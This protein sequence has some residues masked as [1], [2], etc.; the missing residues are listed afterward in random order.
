MKETIRRRVIDPGTRD[1]WISVSYM[2]LACVML[3][4]HVWVT[5]HFATPENGALALRFPWVILAGAGFF[6]GR[7]W[8]DKTFWILAALLLLKMLRV[9]VP[10]PEKLSDT[11]TVY[12]LCLYAFGICYAAGRVLDP[13][14]RKRFVSLFCG[15]WT[16]A[17]AALA[18]AGLYA[19]WNNA[20]IPNLGNKPIFVEKSRLWMVYHPVEGGGLASVTVA[21]AMIGIHLSRRRAVKALYGAAAA[22]IFLAGVF[23]NSRTS[24]ILSAFA[25]SA[26]VCLAAYEWRN[27]GKESRRQKALRIAGACLLF[28]VLSLALIVLQTKIM[29]L[30]NAVRSRG[31]AWVPSALA[32]DAAAAAPRLKTREFVLDKGM[33]GFLTDRV[34][35]WAKALEAM[36]DKPSLF[37][38]GQSVYRFMEPLR[39][40]G[41]ASKY[42][43]H[44]TFMQTLW[45][46]GIPGL[47][48]FAGF[49]GIFAVNA[50]RLAADRGAPRWMRLLPL[51]AVLCWMADFVDCTGYCN[52]GKPAMTVLYFF[53]GLTIAAALERRKK[54]RMKD[55]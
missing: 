12:E 29:P 24:D 16:A 49:F 5:V 45:E 48:L 3:L 53:T 25:V 20:V 55:A 46:N 23:T 41:L 34:R 33:N 21:I 42:H 44:S 32:E 11:Q 10:M 27:S 26:P 39:E 1:R 40:Y 15:L 35:I 50:F 52:W 37:L 18:C 31:G 14:D 51:P 7:L 47:L 2:V 30:Y 9:A 38:T 13:E 19:V 43:L 54:E 4:H 6:L 8:K 22:V 17:M 28:A 36:K